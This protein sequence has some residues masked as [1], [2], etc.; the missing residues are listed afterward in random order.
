M[1][2]RNKKISTVQFYLTVL[3]TI[4]LL[5]SNIL[6]SKQM[7]L[8]F[9][10]IMTCG[11]WVF[12]VTYIL[13]DVFSEVYGYGWSR[14]SC[15]VAFVAN[16]IAVGYFKL[17]II[18]PYPDYYEGQ[19]ALES[20][21]GN[22]PRILIASMLAYVVGDFINDKVFQRLKKDDTGRGFSFRAIMSSL[23]GEMV[24][25]GI[26]MPIVFLGEMPLKDLAIMYIT[27]VCVKVGYEIIILPVTNLV[28][29]AVRKA[30][31]AEG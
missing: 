17:A 3:S 10:I 4:C 12:P 22:T 11:A 9:G 18:S 14:V 1:K 7:L 29:R 8:P 15:Y 19:L 26:F 25:S 24:D 13:S 2:N 31:N 28:V 20:V 16:I 27:E 5:I 30:E 21:L 6:T 23:C